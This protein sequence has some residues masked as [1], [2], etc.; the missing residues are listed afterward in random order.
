METISAANDDTDAD[1]IPDGVEFVQ[2]SDINVKD[3][4][5]YYD[6]KL[7]VK[8]TLRDMLG[9]PWSYLAL[10]QQQD[11]L[12]TI[13]ARTD[14]IKGLLDDERFKSQRQAI[15]RLYFAFFLRQ[16]DHSGLQHWID[17][18][19]K[20][21]TMAQ[22]AGSFAGSDEFVS[23]YGSLSNG[24]FVDLVYQNVLSRSPDSGGYDYWT[25][26]LQSGEVTKG[27][28][29]IGFSESDEYQVSSQ[30]RGR[31]V[32]L[33]NQLYRRAANDGE[34]TTWQDNLNNGTD[35]SVLISDIIN[36]SEYQARFY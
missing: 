32:L 28:M 13:G 8:Q 23:R 11:A 5:I 21:M 19:E 20:G 36:S 22:I 24:D 15:S 27:S 16:P 2:G 7:F 25:A 17:M 26:R 3:N 12:A 30:H 4:D 9:E 6:D 34:F 18:F 14:W 33:F 1:G 31:V 10:Q 35:V 29:M